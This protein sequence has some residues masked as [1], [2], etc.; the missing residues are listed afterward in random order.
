[1]GKGRGEE[2]EKESGIE[3]E[4][5]KEVGGLIL[6]LCGT[7]WGGVGREGWSGKGGR[8]PWLFC[9]GDISVFE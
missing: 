9:N 2:G 7:F 8:L 6:H 1:M 4:K 5:V 3:E